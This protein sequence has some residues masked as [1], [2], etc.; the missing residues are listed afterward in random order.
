MKGEKKKKSLIAWKKEEEIQKD[1][2]QVKSNRPI[3]LEEPQG[4]PN[5]SLILGKTPP[6]I[7]EC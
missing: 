6:N 2:S 7:L 5:I 3:R 4:T 1:P